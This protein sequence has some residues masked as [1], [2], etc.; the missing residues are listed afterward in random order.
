[1]TNQTKRVTKTPFEVNQIKL[2]NENQQPVKEK[3]GDGTTKDPDKRQSQL[4][5]ICGN[6]IGGKNI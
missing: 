1:M 2:S 4:E 6:V 5:L 3:Y